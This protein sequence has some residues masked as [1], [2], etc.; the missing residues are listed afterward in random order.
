MELKDF[1]C[2]VC[3]YPLTLTMSKSFSKEYSLF[4]INCKM[5]KYSLKSIGCFCINDYPKDE[6]EFLQL[7]TATR[8]E[9]IANA[10]R[11]KLLKKSRDEH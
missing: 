2:P 8:S 9:A 6:E 5:F 4:C 7:Y 10:T 11:E 1:T 3:D